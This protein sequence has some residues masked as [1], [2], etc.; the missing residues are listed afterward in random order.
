[1][2]QFRKIFVLG[3][4][5]SL[6]LLAGCL[7]HNLAVQ[8]EEN[9][10][11]GDKIVIGVPVPL[12]FAEENT[13]FLKGIKMAQDDINVSGING[14]KIKLEI[15]DDQGNF[16]KA[17][18]IAQAFSKDV[19]MVAVIGHWFSDICI[20]VS[21]IYEEAGML[22]IVPT[23]SNPDLT[24]KG[25]HYIFQSITS[26]KKI[27]QEMCAYVQSKGYKKV[28]VYYEESSYGENLADAIEKEA[29][30]NGIKVVD[31]CSGLVTEEQFKKAHDKWKA[32]EFEA[33]LL[34]VN[35]PE[36]A[37]FINAMRKMN[38]GVGII[39]ADGLDVD[40]FIDTLGK[41]AEGV[42]IATTYSPYNHRTELEQF[43]KQYKKKYH[44]EPDVWSIQGY[45]S[46]QLIARAIRQTN[47]YSPT[48]L[49]DYLHEMQPWQTVSGAISFNQNGEIDGR[50][51]YK[52]TVVNGQYQYLD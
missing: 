25:Y 11:K 9:A 15:A 1:M 40:N 51:I 4:L 13:N 22:T 16:K 7:N 43:K 32:L 12:K 42:V 29:Q 17:V 23:V 39:S 48:V 36:G 41:N 8:R 31:R 28:V 47:S 10:G 26:D 19:S 38:Q 5:V 37:N 45:E 44:E 33:L 14:K 27:A 30:K 50:E 18:D 35:M 34:A 49:A 6:C 24:E 20:P 3:L 52:K 2:N 46:L 21:N